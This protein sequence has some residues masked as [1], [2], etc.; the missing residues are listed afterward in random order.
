MKF[1]FDINLSEMNF[2]EWKW[3]WKTLATVA[4]LLLS[5]QLIFT[6]AGWNSLFS[7]FTANNV[8]EKWKEAYQKY[9]ALEQSA[10]NICIA[11]KA[12]DSAPSADVSQ[13]TTQLLAYQ[14]N[15][16]NI[17]A[18]YNAAVKNPLDAGLV[19][20]AELPSQAPSMNDM[21]KKVGCE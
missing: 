19:K 13:R 3:Y 15:Y 8:I 12:V 7:I 11:Q 16:N 10:N 6:L 5:A 17:S 18:Q 1:L 4:G 20:P 14:R 2:S 9:E 21:L